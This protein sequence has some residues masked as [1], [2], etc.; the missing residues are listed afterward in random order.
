MGAGES[1]TSGG[2]GSGRAGSGSSSGQ[3]EAGTLDEGGSE[4]RGSPG[5]AEAPAHTSAAVSR[6]DGRTLI[7]PVSRTGLTGG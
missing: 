5:A 6:T 4:D 1:G 2:A 3:G 7:H